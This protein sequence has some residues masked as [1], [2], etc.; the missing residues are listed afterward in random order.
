M[1]YHTM[2]L[3]SSLKNDG[4][5]AA[6][7]VLRSSSARSARCTHSDD[8]LARAGFE[9]EEGDILQWANAQV[10]ATGQ[11]IRMKSF[12]VGARAGTAGRT[13]VHVHC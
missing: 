12:K 10:A 4:G 6:A 8:S 9:L 13:C 7:C 3:L 2:K 1:R 5:C 11:D